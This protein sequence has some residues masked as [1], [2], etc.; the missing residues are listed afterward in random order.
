MLIAEDNRVNQIVL[1]KMLKK[2]HLEADIVADGEDVLKMLS[3]QKYDLIFMDQNM[4][5]MSGVEATKTLRSR[6]DESW[7]VG[8]SASTMEREK[9]P[10]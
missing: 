7:I 8:C 1:K 2:Y 6:G 4:P 10:V 3:D 5:V 9:K